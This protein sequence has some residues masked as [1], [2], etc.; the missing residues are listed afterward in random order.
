MA[1]SKTLKLPLSW[2]SYFS[3]EETSDLSIK[4]MVRAS[5][6]ESGK[7]RTSPGGRAVRRSSGVWVCSV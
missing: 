2:R 5:P 7:Q 4:N 3:M 1:V 6:G